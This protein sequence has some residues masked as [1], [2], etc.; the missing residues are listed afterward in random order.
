[1]FKWNQ[2]CC[3]QDIHAQNLIIYL[4]NVIVNVKLRSVTMQTLY[5]N[6]TVTKLLVYTS[7]TSALLPKNSKL[8]QLTFLSHGHQPEDLTNR[9]FW[10][11]GCV[12]FQK[13]DLSERRLW[14][15][16]IY[17]W[18]EITACLIS[19]SVANFSERC[20]RCGCTRRLQNVEML[21]VMSVYNENDFFHVRR[22]PWDL[23]FIFFVLHEKFC[24]K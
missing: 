22:R 2:K 9:C 18:R 5:E 14:T 23:T 19:Y 16:Q 20:W 17:Q 11:F 21:I 7:P 24:W 6:H 8:R 10:I 15:T 13:N 12:F 4:L 3:H 1:M